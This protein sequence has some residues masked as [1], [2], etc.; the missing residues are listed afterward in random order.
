M[1]NITVIFTSKVSQEGGS[2]FFRIRVLRDG[3]VQ[4]ISDTPIFYKNKLYKSTEAENRQ[5]FKNFRIF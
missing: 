2:G 5:I 4:V 1:S 3:T